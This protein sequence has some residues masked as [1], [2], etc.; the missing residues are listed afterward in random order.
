[1]RFLQL[2]I[3]FDAERLAAEVA[4]IPESAW[5]AHPQNFPG[6]DALALI[7]TDGDP[8]SDARAG[9]MGPTPHL[10]ACPYLMQVPGS[11]GRHLGPGQADAGFRAMRRSPPMWTP[12]ITGAT[13]CAFTCPSSPSPPS[14]SF[15][16]MRR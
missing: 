13:T 7:T 16:G 9:A 6:N 12:T 8:D 4:A 3:L 2:P 14:G 11:A 1:M 10:L 5:R 15:A